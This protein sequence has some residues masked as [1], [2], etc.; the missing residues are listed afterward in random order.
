MDSWEQIQKQAMLDESIRR[1]QEMMASQ[2]PIKFS[3]QEI[4]EMSDEQILGL[5][6]GEDK[7]VGTLYH[8]TLHLLS[9]EMN[10]RELLRATR[11]HWSVTPGFWFAVIAAVASVVTLLV[12]WFQSR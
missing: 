9:Y 11:P 8:D 6:S 10:R 5:L 12:P 4:R 7:P 3:V 1:S 2:M